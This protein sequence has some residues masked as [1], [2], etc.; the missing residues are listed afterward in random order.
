MKKG[1]G[2]ILYGI[3]FGLLMV[4][5]FTSLLQQQCSLFTFKKLTGYEAP[6]QKPEFS[7]K[8][9]KSGDYQYD[10]EQYLSENIGFREPIIRM[11]NQ[12]VYDFYKKT[13]NHEVAIEKDGWLYHTDGLNQYFGRMGLK[14]KDDNAAFAKRL[15]IEMRSL[16]KVH[17][18]L[19]GYDVNLLV[20]TLPTK[21]YL[22]P[23][24]LK[25]HP[26]IDT[27][28]NATR[29]Y[30]AGL[31]AR[32]VPYINMNSWFQTVQDTLP[33][34]L[35][36]QKGSHWAAGAPLAVDSLLGMMGYIGN[37]SLVDLEMGTPYPVYDVSTEDKDLEML[38]NL[39]R[40]Q[41]NE[42]VIE[43]PVTL[44]VSDSTQFPSAFIVGTSFYWYLKR[45]VNLNEIFRTRDF[46][47]YGTQLYT[48][49]ERVIQE[50]KNVDLLWELLSHDYVI[51]F[52]NGPQLYMDGFFF[53]G[54]ALISLCID[55]N[56]FREKQQEVADSLYNAYGASGIER[57]AFLYE[58]SNVLW[59][60]PE[61]FEE[62]RGEA[63]PTIR[64]PKVEKTLA[65]RALYNNSRNRALM[66]IEAVRDSLDFKVVLAAEA[67]C[68]MKGQPTKLSQMHLTS[69]EFFEVETKMMVDSF[70]HQP[71]LLDSLVKSTPD[72][73]DI[74]KVLFDKAC[75]QMA[76]RVERGDYDK[77]TQA[78]E[79][80]QLRQIIINMNNASSLANI[81]EKAVKQGKTLEKA[82]QDDAMWVF[83]NAKT[84]PTID[85]ELVVAF[86]KQYV[87]EHTF[88]AYPKSMERIQQKAKDKDKPMTFAI[89]DD[90]LYSYNL[91]AQKQ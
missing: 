80:F 1:N 48:D 32:D 15:D 10:L 72:D 76:M 86:W 66:E 19:K 44:K 34:D 58:A 22:F 81:K 84:L 63:T 26:F 90:V 40:P 33:F 43:Y 3:L 55:D 77:N 85:H 30:E 20:F 69:Y 24:H 47:Y 83:Q 27:T 59:S 11:Y 17:E 51:Y 31:T 49:Q 61:L 6:T 46:L 88:K 2:N 56:R 28:F 91:K 9:Y 50:K 67:D 21:T 54:K 62:L 23:Q 13:Y 8:D 5:L 71:L 53:A 75:Q 14:F 36:P 29:Y 38:L 73:G 78:I 4:F 65:Q 60:N 42:P 25:N 52:K 35:F 39:V 74:H 70:W 89:L 57:S 64:N 37:Q 41:Y 16:K 82:I 18:I 12:Y 68:I 79:A 7:L 87:I 45:R